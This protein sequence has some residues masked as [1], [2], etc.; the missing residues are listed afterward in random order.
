MKFHIDQYIYMVYDFFFFFWKC[1]DLIVFL[2][3]HIHEYNHWRASNFFLFLIRKLCVSSNNYRINSRLWKKKSLLISLA[4]ILPFQGTV[5]DLFSKDENNNR[6][7]TLLLTLGVIAAN[8][9]YLEAK[10]LFAMCFW[11]PGKEV[12]TMLVARVVT[13]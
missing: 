2:F 1:N 7:A 10:A 13:R 5:P 11:A 8:S 3:L 9:P 12:D 4:L 6:V